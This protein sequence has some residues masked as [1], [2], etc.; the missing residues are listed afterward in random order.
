MTNE[1]IQDVCNQA[2]MET[3]SGTTGFDYHT[4]SQLISLHIDY[5]FVDPNDK[6]HPSLYF[7]PNLEEFVGKGFRIKRAVGGYFYHDPGLGSLH[8]R[9][10][11]L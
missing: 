10:I 5:H 6:E 11:Q 1:A 8:I 9:S 2:G 3:N 7:S 4:D